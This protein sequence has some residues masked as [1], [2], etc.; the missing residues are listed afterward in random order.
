MQS[1]DVIGRI[2]NELKMLRS[3]SQLLVNSFCLRPAAG[4]ATMRAGAKTFFKKIHLAAVVGH[5]TTPL[6]NVPKVLC[7]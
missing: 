2:K 7:K 5:C 1:M 4:A 3:A 6:T